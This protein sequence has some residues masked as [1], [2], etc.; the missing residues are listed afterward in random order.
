MCV[1]YKKGHGSPTIEA[2]VL[3][4]SYKKITLNDLT[5]G[6]DVKIPHSRMTKTC[7]ETLVT[8]FVKRMPQVTKGHSYHLLGVSDYYVMYR[9]RAQSVL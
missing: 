6:G 7:W 1:D 3:N 5:L 2:S 4:Y 9:H 8:C